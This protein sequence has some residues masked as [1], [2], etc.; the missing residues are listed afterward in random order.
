M[1]AIDAEGVHYAQLNRTIKEVLHAGAKEVHLKNVGGQRY[2]GDGLTGNQR[3]IIEGTPGN[4]MAAY[5]NGVEIVVKGNAQD[6]TGNTMNDGR[7]IIHGNSGDTL[8]YAMRG[9]EAF[10]KGNVGYRV[11]IHMKEYKEKVPVIVVGGRAGDFLG[12]YMAGGRIVL[13][14]LNLS[15]KEEICGNFCGTGM[16]NGAIYIRGTIDSFKLG[17]EVKVVEL[18]EED[19]DFLRRYVKR[20]VDYFGYSYDYIMNKGFVK[21]IPFNKRPYGNLYAY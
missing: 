20:F 6:A 13:L 5:M 9:G 14:G 19:M 12:E 18:G 2:I 7:I 15:D 10:V 4:D 8:G 11:G 21:L 17:K 1:R 16:H 3:I